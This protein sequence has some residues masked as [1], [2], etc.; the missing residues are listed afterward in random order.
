MEFIKHFWPTVTPDFEVALQEMV[1][2][3]EIPKK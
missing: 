2:S 3:Q 1:V